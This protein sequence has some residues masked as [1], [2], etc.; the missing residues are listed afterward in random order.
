MVTLFAASRRPTAPTV[1]EKGSILG[2]RKR[3]WRGG[4]EVKQGFL[5]VKFVDDLRRRILCS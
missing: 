1:M 4:K 3:E 2:D 5:E